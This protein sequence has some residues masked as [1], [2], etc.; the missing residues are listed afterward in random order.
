MNKPVNALN[1]STIEKFLKN[2]DNVNSDSIEGP[3]LPKSK[4]YMKIVGLPYKIE[5]GVITP[6][7][8]ESILK[9]TYLFKDVIL[10]L[11]PYVIK[12]SSK[13]DIAVV[14]VD[15]WDSQSSSL[16]KN[17]INCRFNIGQFVATV[18][19]TNM[20]SGIPQCKNCWKWGHSTLSC[21][22][23]VSRYAKCYGAHVTEHHREKA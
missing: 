3:C 23:H 5:Q 7:Y 20:N 16:A 2:I 9:E 21:H 10:A 6:D 8:I 17:I 19:G 12:A 14:W 1:L 13:S 4:S 18:H 15:I 22:F 11:K